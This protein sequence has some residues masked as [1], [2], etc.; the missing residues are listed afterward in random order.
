MTLSGWPL[1]G[2]EVQRLRVSVNGE[3]LAETVVMQG[4]GSW[5]F[6][7]GEDVLRRGL[8]QVRL[9]LAWANPPS[10]ADRRALSAAFDYV[11][12]DV[13]DGS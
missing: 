9:H 12:I 6:R 7:V 3:L 10:D 8:N 1:G 11:S 4:E 13:V 5:V 2:D